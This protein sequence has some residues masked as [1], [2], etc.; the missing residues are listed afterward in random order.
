MY[1]PFRLL[2]GQDG[3]FFTQGGWLCLN[4]HYDFPDFSGL[5]A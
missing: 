3:H 2:G 4:R 5:S 1:N